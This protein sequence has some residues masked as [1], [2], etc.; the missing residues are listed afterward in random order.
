MKTIK[1]L[2]TQKNNNRS[3]ASYKENNE[4][5]D[6]NICHTN[7]ISNSNLLKKYNLNEKNNKNAKNQNL[8]EIQNP[9]KKQSQKKKIEV[10]QKIFKCFNVNNPNNKN[11][12]EKK[13]KFSEEKKVKISSINQKDENKINKDNKENKK[14]KIVHNKENEIKNCDKINLIDQKNTIEISE[15]KFKE[16]SNP[17]FLNQEKEREERIIKYLSITSKNYTEK[18][19]RILIQN[20]GAEMYKHMNQVERATGI[21]GDFMEK[22][23]ISCEIRTKMVD[24]MVEVIGVYKLSSETF[25][26][27]VFIMDYFLYK[28]PKI[29]KTQDIHELGITC[30]YIA[31]KFQDVCP[32][33][34]KNILEKIGHNYFTR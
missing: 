13:P 16:I 28:T 5:L 20:Y 25:F 10:K 19:N 34:M 14:I 9:E 11:A 29:L 12:K 4:N 1:N 27:C 8:L 6:L 3:K 32:L 21:P 22:H 33:N 26:Q 31:T 30:I 23:K 15:E 18:G 24:W 7:I 17:Y 2:Q